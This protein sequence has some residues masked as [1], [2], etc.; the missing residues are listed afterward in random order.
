MASPTIKMMP[1]FASP[2]SSSLVI[3]WTLV[4]DTDT[5]VIAR[6]GALERRKEI[7]EFISYVTNM[8]VLNNSLTMSDREFST[9]EEKFTTMVLEE[10]VYHLEKK[11][12]DRIAKLDK[13]K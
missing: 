8:V 12:V 13:V 11:L 10:R 4:N 2:L 5:G 3:M 7:V 9:N 6:L 1:F